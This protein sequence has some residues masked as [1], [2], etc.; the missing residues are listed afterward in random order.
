MA[1]ARS[2]ENFRT[3]LFNISVDL[4]NPHPETRS[5]DANRSRTH[6]RRCLRQDTSAAFLTQRI[7]LIRPTLKRSSATRC[8]VERIVGGTDHCPCRRCGRDRA[9]SRYDA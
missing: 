3:G 4:T 5:T 6:H 8:L 7:P 1:H 9:R 2:R